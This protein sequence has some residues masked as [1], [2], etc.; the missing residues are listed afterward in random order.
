MKT[1]LTVLHF[2][3]ARNTIYTQTD[4]GQVQGPRLTPLP[5]EPGLPQGMLSTLLV[6]SFWPALPWD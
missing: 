3:L 2:Y 5:K 6:V 1:S 4:R